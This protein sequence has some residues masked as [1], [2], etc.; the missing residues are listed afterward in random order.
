MSRREQVG[1]ALIGLVFG[2]VLSWSFLSDPAVVQQ[3]LRFEDSYMFLFFGAAFA[4]SAIG[5]RV[6]RAVRERVG[7]LRTSGSAG[8]R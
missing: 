5:V 6:V 7:A 3:A 1:G 4:T 2:F 8:S